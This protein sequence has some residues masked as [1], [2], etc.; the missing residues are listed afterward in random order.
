VS[1]DEEMIN[2]TAQQQA[3]L[4]ATKLLTTVQ[5]MFDALLATR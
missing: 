5:A 4:A 1:L 2:L 3:Y